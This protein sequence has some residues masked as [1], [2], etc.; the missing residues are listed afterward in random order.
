MKGEKG[1]AYLAAGRS[2]EHVEDI[3]LLNAPER[4]RTAGSPKPRQLA[5]LIDHTQVRADASQRDIT[6]LCDEA[7]RHG[8]ASVSINPAWTSYCAKRLAGSGVTVNP[9]VGFPLGANTAHVKVEEAREAVR[10]GAGELDVV[11]NIGALRSGFPD[12]VERELVAIVR[13][14]KGT[15]VKVILETSYLSDEDKIR[16]CEM[17]VRA[18]AAFVKTCT[19]FGRHGATLEDV[20]LMRRVVGRQIGVKAAGGIRTYRDTVNMLEAGANR[21]GTSSG[22]AILREMG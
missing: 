17:S 13:A 11:I 22:V 9:C 5:G 8:F 18:G 1:D 7:I 14:V 10:N 12:F 4:G 3:V 15:P 19:G 16:V 2:I 21:I 6:L 20:A